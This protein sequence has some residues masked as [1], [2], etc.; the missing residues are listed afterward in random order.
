MTDWLRVGLSAHGQSIAIR[1]LQ[2]DV[3]DGVERRYMTLLLARKGQVTK[4]HSK[5]M[6]SAIQEYLDAHDGILHWRPMVVRRNCTYGRFDEEFETLVLRERAKCLCREASEKDLPWEQHPELVPEPTPMFAHM[7]HSDL[8]DDH[9]LRK[10]LKEFDIGAIYRLNF[11]ST[12]QNISSSC[13]PV[14]APIGALASESEIIEN[15]ETEKS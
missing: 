4:A 12:R 2:A 10:S 1:Q 3:T 11:G 8:P 9:P 13:G 5:A 14:V 15:D 7:R 6:A